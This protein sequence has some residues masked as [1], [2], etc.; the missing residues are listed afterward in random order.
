M[1]GEPFID[2][3]Q[4]Q[5]L[6]PI[7]HVHKARTPTLLLQGRRT[8]AVRR[9]RP[10]ELFVTPLCRHVSAERC[11]GEPPLPRGRAGQPSHRLDAVRRRFGW[12]GQWIDVPVTD[13]GPR[14]S[15]SRG[16]G[17]SETG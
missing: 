1:R 2:R 4:G 17:R 3:D 5:R 14:A 6:R 10:E 16:G 8:S 11:C 15:G 7:K 9:A 13:D 12:L